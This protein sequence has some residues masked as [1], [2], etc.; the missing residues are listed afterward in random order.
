MLGKTLDEATAITCPCIVLDAVTVAFINVQVLTPPQALFG[1][2]FGM[3]GLV[4]R[5]R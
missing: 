2:S 4:Y 1:I 5:F 3:C